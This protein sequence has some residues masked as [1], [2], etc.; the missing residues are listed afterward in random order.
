MK[1]PLK[2]KKNQE[3]RFEEPI[4]TTIPS[5]S[6]PSQPPRT[7]QETPREDPRPITLENQDQEMMEVDISNPKDPKGKGK[8]MMRR[9]RTKPTIHYNIA[10]DAMD[11]TANI[12]F[13]ELVKVSPA[14][15]CELHS[16]TSIRKKKPKQLNIMDT[17]EQEIDSTAAYATFYV[18]GQPVRALVD[19]GA[20]KTCMSKELCDQLRLKIDQP[21]RVVFTLGNGS[22]QAALGTISN[23]P[24]RIDDQVT[25]TAGVEVLSTCPV[26]L[27]LGNNWLSKCGATVNFKTKRLE[28]TQGSKIA[29]TPIHF[30]RSPT[31]HANPPK[32]P[33]DWYKIREAPSED[34]SS[35]DE[36]YETT[37]N[38]ESESESESETSSEEV[39]SEE[40]DTTTKEVEFF[41]LEQDETPRQGA[42]TAERDQ[43][44]D[45]TVQ[46][47]MIAAREIVIPENAGPVTFPGQLPEAAYQELHFEPLLHPPPQDLQYVEGTIINQGDKEFT[48]TIFNDRPSAKIIARGTIFGVYTIDLLSKDN[49]DEVQGFVF[50]PKIFHNGNEVGN[51]LMI[52]H[53]SVDIGDGPVLQADHT[54][55][56]YKVR[57]IEVVAVSP[58]DSTSVPG[59]LLV[60]PT[61]KLDF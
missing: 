60:P 47:L 34:Y 30:I 33:P 15:R 61:K 25:I 59:R 5:E 49:H 38:D 1:K 17:N 18:Y 20:A 3:L 8:A 43:E 55:N 41:Q 31:S 39:S 44:D 6:G 37:D 24:V 11:R 16:A 2:A 48:M 50:N 27:V 23:L 13:R 26:H 42:I 52:M 4:E 51:E 54:T 32:L 7:L 45:G 22:K 28:V 53:A 9:P 21:S 14:L 36:S 56:H 19:T 46:Y 10:Q 35:D 40:V 58:E 12:T 57:A 29:S